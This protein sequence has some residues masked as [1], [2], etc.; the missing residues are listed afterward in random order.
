MEQ[1]WAQNTDLGDVRVGM[2]VEAM[3]VCGV[4]VEPRERVFF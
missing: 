3:R 4:R 2:V 1:I